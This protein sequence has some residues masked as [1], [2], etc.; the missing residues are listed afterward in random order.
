LLWSEIAMP[1][2]PICN[3]GV[4]ARRGATLAG[5]MLTACATGPVAPPDPGQGA[6]MSASSPA[7]RV[8]F[9]EFPDIALPPGTAIDLDR[10]LVLGGG[11]DWTGRLVFT[12]R[13][14]IAETYDYFRAEMPRLGWTEVTSLRAAT[15]LL[16][17]H[18]GPRIAT[19]QM[20]GR[21]FGFALGGVG[22]DLTMAP[23][24]NGEA[25]GTGTGLGRGR[26]STIDQAPL[27]APRL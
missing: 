3:P 21:S 11:R 19:I 15:S 16:V 10:S 17:F 24:G 23:R 9:G 2:N 13:G 18:Q 14:G 22:V 8:A 20:A 6:G 4:L 25:P 26:S 27:P 5:L 12:A 1:P 7:S